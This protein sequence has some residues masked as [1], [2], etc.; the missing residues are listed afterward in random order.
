MC[1]LC[2]RAHAH[3]HTHTYERAHARTRSRAH[4]RT[5]MNDHARVHRGYKLS[6]AQAP[7][8]ETIAAA[9]LHAVHADLMDH[10][11]I[12]V[13]RGRGRGGRGGGWEGGASFYLHT[14]FCLV[15]SPAH[16]ICRSKDN[17]ILQE[18]NL[19]AGNPPTGGN[20]QNP[21]SRNL[22][23]QNKGTPTQFVPFWVGDTLILRTQIP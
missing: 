13:R 4:T 18:I 12:F 5:H 9:C 19:I 20:F 3:T 1:G 16:R 10:R 23:P 17:S 14:I 7:L 22:G 11:S 21:R 8:R 2:V 15:C 6:T